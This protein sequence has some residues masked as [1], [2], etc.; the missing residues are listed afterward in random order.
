MN[1]SAGRAAATMQYLRTRAVATTKL[2]IGNVEGHTIECRFHINVV[3]MVDGV[4]RS[5]FDTLAF[6]NELY[7]G[8][9]AT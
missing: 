9:A 6:L 8:E 4:R 2:A 1:P 3:W 7:Q 5:A